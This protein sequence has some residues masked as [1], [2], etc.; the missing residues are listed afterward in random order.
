MNALTSLTLAVSLIGSTAAAEPFGRWTEQRFPFLS[1]N[2]WA[3]SRAGVTLS[4][5]DAVSL[6]WTRTAPVKGNATSATWDWSVEASVPATS[7]T[8]KGGDD[9]NLALYFVFMP[10]D[11]AER[12]RNAGI[13]RLMR[14]REA[15]VLMYVWGGNYPRGTILPSPYLEE[16]GRTIPLRPASAGTFRETVDLAADYTRAFGAPK[17]VLVGL[18]VSSDSDD[19]GASIRAR[20]SDLRLD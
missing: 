8:E 9:R 4:S 15:R 5:D 11:Q 1:G 14:I 17:T 3:Q 13:R 10:A 19:T 18:A 7:L 2:D 12:Y 20:V 6:I 16:R